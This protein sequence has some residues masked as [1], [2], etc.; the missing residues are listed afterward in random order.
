MTRRIESPTV[1]RRLRR[2]WAAQ[3]T[4]P[5]A[6]AEWFYEVQSAQRT[7]PGASAEWVYE[8]QN[9][10]RHPITGIWNPGAALPSSGH[11]DVTVFR[12]V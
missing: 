2:V 4:P 6:S 7:P 10:Q 11:R 12:R 1:G 9:A 8:V 5:G 3:R